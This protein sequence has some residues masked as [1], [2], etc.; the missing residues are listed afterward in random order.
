MFISLIK[1]KNVY[2]YD[3]LC[4][5]EYYCFLIILDLILSAEL[6]FCVIFEFIGIELIFYNEN[7][8]FHE[9]CIYITFIIFVDIVY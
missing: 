7:I 5:Y 4:I 1:L 6:A 9:R 3:I 8:E 2:N